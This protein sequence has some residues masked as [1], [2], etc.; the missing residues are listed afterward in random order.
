MY[1]RGINLALNDVKNGYVTVVIFSVSQ[2]WYHDIFRL[3]ETK[4]LQL[5]WHEVIILL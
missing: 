4:P 1:L 3:K 5:E 2:G